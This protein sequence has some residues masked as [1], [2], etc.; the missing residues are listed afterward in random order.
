MILRDLFSKQKPLLQ[1]F[2][3]AW[4]NYIKVSRFIEYFPVTRKASWKWW[5]FMHLLHYILWN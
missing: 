4:A 2:S 5:Y 3:T 1:D